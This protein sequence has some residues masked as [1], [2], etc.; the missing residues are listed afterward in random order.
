MAQDVHR[1]TAGKVEISAAVLA[2]QMAVFTAH[3]PKFAPG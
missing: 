2:D 1:D 3:R